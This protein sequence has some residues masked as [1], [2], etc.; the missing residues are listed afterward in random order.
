MY[1]M[2]RIKKIEAQNK[3]TKWENNREI[4]G[5]MVLGIYKKEERSRVRKKQWNVS[6]I[7]VP[8]AS[9]S[10]FDKLKCQI[11]NKVSIFVSKLKLRHKT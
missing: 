2:A 3:N 6:R 7:C 1:L 10:F 9:F 11:R 5:Y 8:K 4:Y